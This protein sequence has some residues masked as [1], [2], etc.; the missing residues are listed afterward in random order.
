MST[1]FPPPHCPSQLIYLFIHLEKEDVG[2]V[3]CIKFVT[4]NMLTGQIRIVSLCLPGGEKAV[5]R[6]LHARWVLMR[7]RQQKSTKFCFFLIIL[8][9]QNNIICDRPPLKSSGVD[10]VIVL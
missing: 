3:T 6:A 8:E 4:Q 7:T 10:L 5:Q 1:F 2:C 9:I